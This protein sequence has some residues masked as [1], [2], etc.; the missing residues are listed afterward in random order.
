MARESDFIGKLSDF[1]KSLDNLV[2]LLQE[3]QKSN[4]SEVVN[5]MF[6]GM[7]TKIS[8]IAENL[9]EVKTNTVEINKNVEKILTVVKSK[10]KQE[11][12]GMFGDVADKKN[13]SSVIE[14]VKTIILIAA[15]VLAIG[16]AFKIIGG[17]DFF[18]VLALGMSILLIAHAFAEI[19]SLKD[20]KGKP[21]GLE[22]AGVA[23]I[24]MI[25]MSGALLVSGFILK[26]MPLIGI[27][28][29]ISI[30]GVGLGVGIATYLMLKGIGGLNTKQLAMAPLVPLI[31][32]L[33]VAG[34]VAAGFILQFMP[35]VTKEQ[36]I[37]SLLVALAVAPMAIAVGFLLK[38]LKDATIPQLIFA[39]LAI[40]IITGGIVAG[41]YIL[42]YM[43]DIAADGKK[44]VMG[45]LVVGGATL[46]MVPTMY[47]LGKS[48]LLKPAAI[49]ELLIGVGAIALLS[50]SVVAA[51]YILQYMPELD[52]EEKIIMG[53]LAVGGVTLAMIPTIF[54][55]KKAG[56]LSP[57]SI[58]ELLIGAGAIVILSTA[59]MLASW[60]LSVGNYSNYPSFEWAAGVG[61]SM[62]SFALPVVGLGMLIMSGIG[63][64]ALLAG[65][66]AVLGM[67]GVIVGVAE[68]LSTYN[69][70]SNNDSYPSIEWSES[71]GMSLMSFSKAILLNSAA[72]LLNSIGSFFGGGGETESPLYGIVDTIIGVAQRLDSGSKGF[73]WKTASHPTKE[74][75][76]GIGLSIMAFASAIKDIN[77]IGS[78]F[79]FGGMDVDDFIAASEGMIKGMIGVAKLMNKEVNQAF[80]DGASYPTKKWAEGV[81]GSLSAFS[82]SLKDF[83]AAGVDAEEVNEV[84]ESMV[85]LAI[86]LIEVA[87]EFN[88]SEG[89]FKVENL[90]GVEY[91][92]NLTASLNAFTTSL[93]K[94]K[95][96]DKDN[97]NMLVYLGE[98]ISDYSEYMAESQ[99]FNPLIPMMVGISLNGMVDVLQKMENLDDDVIDLIPE[100]GN[101]MQEYSEY[102][103]ESET[104]DDGLAFLISSSIEAMMKVIPTESDIDPLW[105]LIDA[106]EALSDLSWKDLANIGDVSDIIGDLSEQ[107]RKL[108]DGKIE[109]LNKLGAGLHVISLIDD[110]KMKLALD[111]IEEKSEILSEI[112][113]EGSV[114][115]GV[116]ESASKLILG[117]DTKEEMINI[118]TVKTDKKTTFEEDLLNYV[119]NIDVNIEKIGNIREKNSQNDKEER[120][121]GR[122][123]NRDESITKPF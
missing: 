79:G 42:Q 76:E 65:A 92:E 110:E 84:Q 47:L 70:W 25:M 116:F 4:P 1:T 45:S 101:A 80:W 85:G 112:V 32:P 31:I 24:M 48:G 44:I 36:I 123:V 114:M 66:G 117:E 99:F 13:K 109:S 88:K 89:V 74:W 121:H 58:L 119:K 18:S 107:I 67:A 8:T 17:V 96:I 54:L 108:D 106:L 33:I 61:L 34:I 86:A 120:L 83:D 105:K 57:K 82:S 95:D 10:Q 68:I 73:D 59:V 30:V 122:N 53:A 60:I 2:E 52:S 87:K 90:P 55:L 3:Q 7:D 64:L 69:G 37:N 71:V 51:A 41:S 5:T 50:V 77:S 115:S 98:S 43:P 12:S 20:D 104:F 22:R 40:P 103:A 15:G 38:G 97:V 46:A 94:T 27:F 118:E 91:G 113:G 39:S 63:A 6:E 49:L 11:E 100:I 26:Q 19:A 14:G 29:L 81:G 56:L 28:E 111:A 23:A 16:M 102:M 35:D 21:I 75:A 72:G 78:T 9:E 93:K 62:L